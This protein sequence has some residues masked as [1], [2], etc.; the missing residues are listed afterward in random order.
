MQQ[1]RG[2]LGVVV[3][4]VRHGLASAHVI[5]DVFDVVIAPVPVGTSMDVI[6]RQIR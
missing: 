4:A 2:T 3:D 5:R 1:V 6:S